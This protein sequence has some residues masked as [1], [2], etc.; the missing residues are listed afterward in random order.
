[1]A[2]FTLDIPP[3]VLR[4]GTEYGSKGRWY[5]ANLWRWYSGE[6]R[7]VG[8]W[9][10]RSTTTV[11]GKARCLITYKDNGN[12]SWAGI[13]T[14]TGLYV[15]SKTGSVSNI[16]P[17]GYTA[18]RPDAITGG[19]YG[20]G[21]YGFGIYG[22]PIPSSDIIEATVWTLDTWGENLVGCTADDGVI[23]EWTPNPAAP[24]LPIVNA[25]TARAI[26]VTEDRIM[27]ALGADDNPRLIRNCDSQDNTDWTETTTNYARRFALQTPGRLMCGK[28]ITSGTL[29]FTDVD[30]WLA[31]FIG[32]PFVYGYSRQGTGCGV[33]SQQAVAATSSQAYWMSQNGFWRYNGFTEPLV[34]D[35]HDY[36]FS[37]I[38]LT[39][40][41][42]IYAVHVSAFGEVWWFYCS[43]ASNEI[44]RYVTHSYRENHWS[45]GQL[46]RLS[47]T[48]R[49]VFQ[50]PLMI[51]NDGQVWDHEKGV[52]HGGIQPF[53]RSGPVEL[54]SG[55]NT[56]TIKQIIP[57]E[58]NAGDVNVTFLARFYPNAAQTTYGPY[59]LSSPTDCL[60]TARQVSVLYTGDD[61]AD[62][63]IGSFRYDAVSRG[64]RGKP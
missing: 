59:S 19:G 35:V 3:G 10:E 17:A 63:R 43:A 12:S 64:K 2:L 46:A 5:D 26:V 6:Q 22:G 45:I 53:A 13:G 21:S 33:I 18:G 58:K 49:G 1:M 39:Q 51:D 15:M 44:D 57:D 40:A 54:G 27:L 9:S 62:F 37:D 32:Q 31:T 50:Y 14:H 41:S 60:F 4:T 56:V 61:G 42:K 52:D 16:T 55:D 8:G 29:I 36:V 34:C 28:R 11:S 48:D 7:P 23:Y 30:V 25:P 24:A 20:S 38:N 47:G